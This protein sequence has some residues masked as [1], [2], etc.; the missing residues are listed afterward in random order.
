MKCSIKVESVKDEGKQVV[1]SVEGGG[2]IK[3]EKKG[4]VAENLPKKGDTIEV[5]LSMEKHEKL[6]NGETVIA[7][8]FHGVIKPAE[9]VSPPRSR[10][11]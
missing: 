3:I 1:V 4:S 8:Q 10:D 9:S 7:G 5:T 2:S 6:Q 11:F